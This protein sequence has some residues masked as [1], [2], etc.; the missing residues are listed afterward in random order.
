MPCTGTAF[1]WIA[2]CAVCVCAACI[3]ILDNRPEDRGL[4]PD[5]AGPFHV[6]GAAA[7][8]GKGQGEGKGGKGGKGGAEGGGGEGRDAGHGREAADAK[9]GPD[10]DEAR[11]DPAEVVRTR[12]FWLLVAPDVAFSA[13]WAGKC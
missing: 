7:G 11:F 2:A 12:M 8:N 5:G 1:R 9:P 13:L 4:R 6:A 3:P 10:I